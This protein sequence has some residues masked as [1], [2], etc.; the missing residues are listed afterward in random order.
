M[1]LNHLGG[2]SFND[3]AQYPVFPWV[4]ADYDSPVLDLK[5]P[6]TF[7]GMRTFVSPSLH[8]SRYLLQLLLILIN[9]AD[10]TKPIGALNAERLEYFKKRM[11][12]MPRDVSGQPP[13]LYGTHYSTPGYVLYYLVRCA[14]EYML[15]LQ[16]GMSGYLIE[17]YRFCVT[18]D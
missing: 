9:D 14:P 7:R 12:E 8:L 15:R 18:K 1:F 13:F 10:L 2:R 11:A 5:K 6:S 3:I 4:I 17:L 16:N